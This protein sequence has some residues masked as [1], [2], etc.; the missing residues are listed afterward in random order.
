MCSAR[1]ISAPSTGERINPAQISPEALTTEVVS[2]VPGE[3]PEPPPELTE[4]PNK[5]DRGE[6]HSAAPIQSVRD[7]G[8]QTARTKGEEKSQA[9]LP[10]AGSVVAW[11]KCRP[12]S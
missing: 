8:G 5:K 10:P 1:A 7:W 12:A 2:R 11:P 6:P 4:R 9:T 3:K